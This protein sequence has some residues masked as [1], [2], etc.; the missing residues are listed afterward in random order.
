M[1]LRLAAGVIMEMVT[2]PKVDQ[3]EHPQ[4][5]YNTAT[6]ETVSTEALDGS[7]WMLLDAANEAYAQYTHPAY[8]NTTFHGVVDSSEGSTACGWI[9]TEV[10]GGGDHHGATC[11]IPF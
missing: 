1:V 10:S 2:T 5:L 8:Y 7:G 3:P 11:G 6:H 4:L 9:L